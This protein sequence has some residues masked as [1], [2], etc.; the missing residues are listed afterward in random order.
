MGIVFKTSLNFTL[1]HIK[2]VI[3]DISKPGEVVLKLRYKLASRVVLT[4]C[5][6]FKSSEWF[7]RYFTMQ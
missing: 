2:R 5:F 7:H 3:E 1:I 4:W 6:D